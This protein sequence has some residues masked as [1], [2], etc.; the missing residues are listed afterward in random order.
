MTSY[1]VI[2]P[3]QIVTRVLDPRVKQVC[4]FL[5]CNKGRAHTYLLSSKWNVDSAIEKG[6]EAQ[7]EQ[8]ENPL[9]STCPVCWEDLQ[10]NKI[11][12]Q[13]C[14]HHLCQECAEQHVNVAIENGKSIE[15]PCVEPS[16]DA[17]ITYPEVEFILQSKT[18]EFN[19]YK[20]LYL[21]K[22][23]EQ[24]R[25]H[26]PCLNPNCTLVIRRKNPSLIDAVCTCGTKMC[27]K[28][29]D[30]PHQPASCQQATIWT[31]KI[32]SDSPNAHWLQLNTKDCP[33]CFKPIQ[34]DGGCN[35]MHCSQCR[36]GFCWQCMGP[37]D[38]NME[39]HKCQPY[40]NDGER[41]LLK[42]ES[43]RYM[44]HLSRHFNQEMSS[45]QDTIL[46][47]K[48][49]SES[50]QSIASF[51]ANILKKALESITEAR[52][53]L[54]WVH[55]VA[56]D[57]EDDSP[58]REIYDNHVSNLADLTEKVSKGFK[59][60]LDKVK[61]GNKPTFPPFID[62]TTRLNRQ[63]IGFLEYRPFSEM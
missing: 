39:G 55:V 37:H 23:V 16:C 18:T 63:T 29:G 38:H 28:C 33:K 47:N 15:I 5:Q 8:L 13:T 4:D 1:E 9:T 11:V 31:K 34:K 24:L 20:Y 19:R 49:M 35:Y 25:D 52:H 17:R 3:D 54:S 36:H 45:K 27:F 61:N 57:M 51:E 12:L 58:E 6:L 41:D 48:R 44:F 50:T 53:V 22:L 46:L 10:D 43:K 2:Q 40:K 59:D 30:K 7:D 32:N 62:M 42:R 14:S 56:F 60:I 21:I 26:R